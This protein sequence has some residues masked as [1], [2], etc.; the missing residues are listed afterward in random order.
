MTKDITVVIPFVDRSEH[1][2]RCIQVLE[3][4]S[5]LDIQYILVDNGSI[6]SEFLNLHQ[7][8]DAM[9]LKFNTGD[10]YWIQNKENKGVLPALRA[11]REFIRSPITVFMHNDVLIWEDK[12]DS[13]VIAAFD[14][15]PNMALAG[16]FGAPGVAADGGRM[17][18]CSNMLGK[19]WGTTG[20]LHGGLNTK[21]VAPATVLDS[22]VMIFRT[23]VLQEHGIPEEWPPHHWYDRL[24]CVWYIDKGYEVGNMGLAFDHG[25]GITS[26]G[27][28]YNQFVREWGDKQEV[29]EKIEDADLYM[30]NTGK[31]LFE[32]YAHRMPLTVDDYW[33]Y[34]WGHG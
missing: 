7:A 13:K 27:E 15:R 18:A 5:E 2:I 17:F 25:G 11:A 9:G 3:L 31:H 6:E 16:F 8:L 4:N 24:F 22:L 29:E 21:L 33:N 28:I 23:S 20:D 12:W 1:T 14:E 34:T 10:N 26:T 30:Y 19:E 32:Q